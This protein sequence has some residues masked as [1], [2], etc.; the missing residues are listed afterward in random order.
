M[1]YI[2]FYFSP[3]GGTKRVAEHI[4][5]KLGGTSMDFTMRCLDMQ[6]QQDSLV[7][8]CFPVYGG[9]V[10]YPVYDRMQQLTGA[11]TPCVPVAVFGNRAVDDALLEM[12][13]IAAT[14]GF[15]AV[16]GAAVVTRH[17][18]EPSI[19]AGRPDVLDLC[20]LDRFLDTL[21]GKDS[22]RKVQLPGDPGYR[23]RKGVSLPLYPQSS[24]ECIGCS[25]CMINCPAEAI[26]AP[27]QLDKSKCMSC[28]RCVEVCSTD[29]RYVPK[30]AKLAATAVV[31]RLCAGR[32]EPQFYIG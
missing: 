15:E 23:K 4:E 24:K 12:S 2:V 19:A 29:S 14:R 10:P 16:A 13:D 1:N 27:T 21:K 7:F 17:S 30:A 31:K 9:R 28:M 3:T 20:K 22:F 18:L 6:F 26:L 8:F 25:N 11:G 32:K 5:Q